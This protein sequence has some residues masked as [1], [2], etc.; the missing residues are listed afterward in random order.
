[1]VFE[2]RCHFT[3]PQFSIDNHSHYVMASGP[4]HGQSIAASPLAPF[5]P[6]YCNKAS[7]TYFTWVKLTASDIH[8]AL[9]SRPGYVNQQQQGQS[10]ALLLFYLNHPVQFV[11]VVGIVVAFDNHDRFWLFTIDDSSGATIDVTC[12]KP[13]KAEEPGELRPI[14][15]NGN[16]ALAQAATGKARN[17]NDDGSLQ[18]TTTSID[19]LSRI[20]VGSVVKVKGTISVF[21]SVRQITLERLEIVPDTSAE[22]RFW[23]QRTQLLT[24]VLSKPWKLSAERQKQ[25]LKEAEGEAEDGKEQAARRVKRLAK[26][27]RREKRHAEKIAKAYEAEERQRNRVAEEMRQHGLG[28][29]V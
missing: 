15:Q 24:D 11:C 7:P 9:R 1:M 13:D 18:E 19:V 27:R 26:E 2:K 16:D 6:A 22:V 8:R 28:R 10:P 5:Y 25:L 14:R 20:G 17:N 23:I 4:P 12:R 29:R 21:R 3:P